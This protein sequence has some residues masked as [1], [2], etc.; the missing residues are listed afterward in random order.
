MNLSRYDGV[1]VRLTTKDGE[2]FEGECTHE[3]AEYCEHEYGKAEDAL[4]VDGWLFYRS[5]I[6]SV[7]RIAEEDVRV[8]MNR[9]LHKMTLAPAPFSMIESGGKKFELRLNDEKRQAV[10]VGDVIRFTRSDDDTEVLWGTVT[11]RRD[12]P[13]FAALY[14]VMPLLECGYTPETLSAASPADMDRYYT[15]AQ[16]QKYGAVAFGLALL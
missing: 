4:D 13:T 8:W 2:V 14:A 6:G 12:F 9:P 7:E 15:P 16:Q 5:Q 3:D 11:E 1:T 10:R